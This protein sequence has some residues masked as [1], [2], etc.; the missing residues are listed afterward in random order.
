MPAQSGHGAL[1]AMEQL[2]TGSPGVFTTI[3]QLNGDIVWP[4]LS[5]PETNVTP[6]NDSIDS[7]VLGILNRG[8]LTFSVN[9]IYNG[10]THDHLTGLYKAMKDN[11]TRGFRLTGPGSPVSPADEWICSGA[12]QAITQ[13]SP[14][15]EGVRTCDVT[16]RMSGAMIIDGAE[17]AS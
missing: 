12:V 16:V 2:P 17:Y 6:H 10:A 4:E 9:F 1:I 14:V 5:R 7:Y 15:Q 13:T 8:P 3:A 11:E